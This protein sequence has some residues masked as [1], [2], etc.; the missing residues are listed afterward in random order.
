MFS[1]CSIEMR[2]ETRAIDFH[3]EYNLMLSDFKQNS[4]VSTNFSPPP[5]NQIRCVTKMHSAV[6][7]M[8]N[9][10]QIHKFNVNIHIYMPDC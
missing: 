8:V 2:T 3:V 9:G 4:D 5:P 1:E 10:G 6:L 7:G